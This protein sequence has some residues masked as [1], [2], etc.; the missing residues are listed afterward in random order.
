MTDKITEALNEAVREHTFTP[1]ALRFVQDTIAKMV[2]LEYQVQT[3]RELRE[4][5]EEKTQSLQAQLLKAENERDAWADREHDLKEREAKVTDNEASRIKAVAKLDGFTGA[6]AM[7]LANPQVRRE[8]L[9]DAQLPGEYDHKG[10]WTAGGGVVQQKA[11]IT[12]TEE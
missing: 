8:I 9:T 11:T 1:D 3:S 4:E 2:T 7:F 6:A 5:L 12:E 10:N